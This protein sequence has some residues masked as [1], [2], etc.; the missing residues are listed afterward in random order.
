[1]CIF[2]ETL[3]PSRIGFTALRSQRK[4]TTY[5]ESNLGCN[6]IRFCVALDRKIFEHVVN[7]QQRTERI[8]RNQTSRIT[9]FE[10]TIFLRTQIMMLYI[11]L[12]LSLSSLC[13]SSQKLARTYLGSPVGSW[14]SELSMNLCVVEQR[15]RRE[16]EQ[17]SCNHLVIIERTLLL[18]DYVCF[19]FQ[20][21]L[22]EH[23]VNYTWCTIHV[24]RPTIE[25]TVAWRE[26]YAVNSN[27][28]RMTPGK[29]DMEGKTIF[30][31]HVD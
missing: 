22:H 27:H 9:N 12:S 10:A 21:I 31:F 30:L 19:V 14:S 18:C 8:S 26:K 11:F 16:A 20:T 29:L 28:D 2:S 17:W 6:T 4:Q 13:L 15:F 24:S 5:E 25:P 23:K 1:M 3:D 7:I